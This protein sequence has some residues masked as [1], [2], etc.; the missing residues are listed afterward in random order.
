MFLILIHYKKP[1]EII[2]QHLAEHR[3]YLDK[4]YKK[5]Y[6]MIS[7]PCNPRT[8]GVIISQL[9]ERDQLEELLKQDPFRIHDLIDY[10][11][12]EFEPVKYHK[13]LENLL[14]FVK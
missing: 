8:G 10:K 3:A 9:K 4:G 12:I 11:I 6:F 14:G 2:D 1:I 5:N 13:D 7:G